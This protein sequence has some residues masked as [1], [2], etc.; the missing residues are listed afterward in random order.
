MAFIKIDTDAMLTVINN[1]N[2]HAD[3]I[4][5]ERKKVND[6]SAANHD[7]VPS[8]ELATSPTPFPS[9]MD[10]STASGTLSACAQALYS[11]AEELRTRRQEAIDLNSNGIT[12]NPDSTI[13]SYYLPDPPE[14]TADV[15]A[16]WN[17][18]DTVDNVRAY[19]SQSVADAEE[20]SAELAEALGNRDG[21][22]S[23]GHTYD[24]IL[25]EIAKHQDVP[26]YAA[27]F[28]SS[29]GVGKYL[30]LVEALGTR[31]TS[32]TPAED[33]NNMASASF[34]SEGAAHDVEILG[35]VFAAASQD[36]V[37]IYDDKGNPLNM[38]SESEAAVEEKGHTG[39]I[40]AL[41]GLL[42]T[43]DT[44]YGTNFLVD[45]ADRLEDN[46]YDGV[47]SA[48]AKVD[49]KYG[50]AYEGSSM[51]PLYGVTMAMGNNPDAALTYLTPDGDAS[52]TPGDRSAERWKLLTE[53]TWDPQVGLEGLTA[54][55]GAASSYRRATDPSAPITNADARATW[56]TGKTIP[57]FVNNVAEK[58][59]TD[60]MKRN[61][62]VVIGNSPE[63]F[64][65][66]AS[67]SSISG[68]NKFGLKDSVTDQEFETL[69]YRVIDNKD[70]AGT[71]A[72]SIGQYYR[73][74]IDSTVPGS[75]SPEEK[76]LE[77]YQS[78]AGAMG[79]LDAMAALRAGDDK[80]AQGAA[81]KN[82]STTLSVFSTV[83]SAG[84]GAAT[85]GTGLAVAGPLLYST[86]STIAQPLIVDDLTKDW[87]VPDTVDAD[88]IQ[89]VLCAQSY[90]DAARYGQLEDTTLNIAAHNPENDNKP[91]SFYS[92]AD[93][94]PAITAPD[95]MTPNAAQS[96]IDWRNAVI[97][98]S[99]SEPTMTNL[100]GAI[101]TGWG[102]G[103]KQAQSKDIIK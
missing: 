38:A 46:S 52:G 65:A 83:L 47:S 31:N 74:E 1:L 73:N 36:G 18:T 91:F 70:A 35:H 92:E 28:I 7:P 21:K 90:V 20:E 87:K 95:P 5:T 56:V 54:A 12:T 32:Y 25:D 6:S 88:D 98:S 49:V 67:G 61:L 85:G 13:V 60:R 27:A 4:E 82:M 3:G 93:G 16:Y 96:F 55:L 19:N 2:E 48:R 76:L 71:V 8:V 22:S 79:Y 40:S 10:P 24:E 66:L 63:E 103:S 44:V 72:A 68:E 42:E 78:A 97:K 101:Q 51:D 29:L 102:R 14:G 80:T 39:R 50:G 17:S 84:V 100:D 53:R 37:T 69:L 15:E 23:K 57:Y 64:N 94:K 26:T 43:P 75:E 62:A 30:D 9:F 99:S 34:D 45:L 86:G 77:K 58:D 81:K 41:N 59:L 89:N 11:L 33:S